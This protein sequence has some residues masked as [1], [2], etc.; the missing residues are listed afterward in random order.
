M[1]I[2]ELF[3]TVETKGDTLKGQQY[4]VNEANRGTIILQA[5]TWSKSP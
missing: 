1:F 4:G 2:T 5:M 3:T